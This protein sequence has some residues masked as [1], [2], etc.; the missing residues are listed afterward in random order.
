MCTTNKKEGVKNK[1][2]IEFIDCVTAFSEWK[3]KRK[4]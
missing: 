1:T 2:G 3:A 4:F